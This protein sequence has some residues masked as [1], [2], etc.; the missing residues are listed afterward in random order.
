MILLVIVFQRT[1]K[2]KFTIKNLDKDALNI[3]N[4][5]L[6][7]ETITKYLPFSCITRVLTFSVEK[8]QSL[9]NNLSR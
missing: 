6:R 4:L 1:P 8:K 9:Q 5:F 3:Q 2:I 7:A